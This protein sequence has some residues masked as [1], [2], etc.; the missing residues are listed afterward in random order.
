MPHGQYAPIKFTLCAGD[1]MPC[2]QTAPEDNMLIRENMSLLFALMD[3][4]DMPSRILDV[5][6]CP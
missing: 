5:S 3:C 6:T 2:I 1:N 4:W